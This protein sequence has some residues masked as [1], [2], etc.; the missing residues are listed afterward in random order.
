MNSDVFPSKNSLSDVHKHLL[1]P[2]SYACHD[3]ESAGIT[4]DL[5]VLSELD[6]KYQDKIIRLIDQ[7]RAYPEIR[8]I[9]TRIGKPF[10]V[11]SPDQVRD[12]I[13]EQ[14][15][16]SS[17]GVD[18]TGGGKLST[19]KVTMELLKGQHEIIGLLKEQRKYAT[20]YKMFIKPMKLK[21]VCDDNKVHISYKLN[22]TVTGRLSASLIHQIPKNIDPDEVGFDFD[23][24]LNIKRLF[25]PDND[26]CE[27]DIADYSQMELRVLA[28]Y[29][30]DSAMLEVF[31]KGLD[32]HIATGAKMASIVYGSPIQYNDTTK[33]F[34][35][36]NH[37][38]VMELIDK[39]SKWRKAA[40]AINFGIVYGKGD[41]S[42]A[43]D[44]KCSQSEATS[45]KTNYFQAYGGVQEF[46]NYVHKYVKEHK[47]VSTMFGNLRRLLA[48]TS[49]NA[50]T[51]NEALRQA[52]NMP[53]QGTAGHYTLCAIINIVDLIKQYNL[54]SRV[55]GT[56][57]DSIIFN[58]YQKEKKIFEEIIPAV[59]CN[60]QNPLIYWNAQCPLAVDLEYS[61][62]SWADV[63]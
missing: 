60:P 35:V 45:F 14:F 1:I 19:N 21:Y 12:A 50:G 24:D 41:E 28:E 22:G 29:A 26:D 44:L 52:V 32:I 36:C 20:L 16:L 42:L 48:I 34:E 39:H 2:G 23:A 5:K 56:V 46:I 37:Q 47:Q 38:S 18:L 55:I 33:I 63:N 9:E 53:I 25:V 3:M 62:I 8:A 11:N 10:N 30:Q 7:I 6:D 58:I 40:K 51:R 4:V 31:Q 54:K 43:V 57:H 59:M 49:S 61:Q 27:L 17:E 13:F 15:G